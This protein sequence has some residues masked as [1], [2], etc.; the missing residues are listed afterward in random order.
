MGFAAVKRWKG[1]DASSKFPK[2]RSA[3]G[4]PAYNSGRAATLRAIA[5]Q[6]I[7]AF[8]GYD[9]IVAPS[10]SCA[11]MLRKHYPMLFEDDA[12]MA[13]R[14]RDVAARSFELVSS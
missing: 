11:G 4:Q 3:A 6:V 12:E 9:Y 2:R 1:A 13:P 8:Q 5:R 10:G 14:A 7:E